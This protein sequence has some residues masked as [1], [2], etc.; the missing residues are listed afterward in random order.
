MLR[1]AEITAIVMRA[2]TEAGF[3]LAGIAAA[4]DS[5]EL[6]YFPQWIAEG[7]AGEMKYLA[8]RDEQGRL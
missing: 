2:A 7:R 5:P 6:E 4:G 1:S 8:A 3:D